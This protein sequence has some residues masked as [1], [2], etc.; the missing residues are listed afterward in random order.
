MTV[1]GWAVAL[2]TFP[3]IIVHEYGHALFCRLL[4][5]RIIEV[6]YLQFDD[7]DRPLGY[8]LHERPTRPWHQILIA[9]GPFML[10]SI[11][12][13]VIGALGVALLAAAE[14]RGTAQVAGGVVI[15]A[16]LSLGMHAF[17]SRG[18]AESAWRA[19]SEP[20]LVLPMRLLA[21]PV[22]LLAYVGSC[23]IIYVHLGYSGILMAMW[24]GVL[25]GPLGL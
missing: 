23:P 24:V 11:L 5:I 13:P 19:V 3:G 15:W 1:P 21:Y 16:G 4:N 2:A 6:C 12:G 18:D 22:L 25:A 7:M 8:V 20:G 17:P 10:N 14:G 9:A